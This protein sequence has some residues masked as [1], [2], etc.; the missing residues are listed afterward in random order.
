MIQGLVRARRFCPEHWAGRAALSGRRSEGRLPHSPVTGS[1][2]SVC[3][4]HPGLW[5]LALCLKNWGEKSGG[6]DACSLMRPLR[7]LSFLRQSWISVLSACPSP[8]SLKYCFLPSE[9]AASSDREPNGPS[10][11]SSCSWDAA[12]RPDVIRVGLLTTGHYLPES[13]TYR[14]CSPQGGEG[15]STPH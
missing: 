2:L 9:T 12:P 14:M 15:D 6:W 1:T 10:S 13:V 3:N 8:P 4:V 11:I 5:P 7:F